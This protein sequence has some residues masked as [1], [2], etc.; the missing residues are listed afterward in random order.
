MWQALLPGLYMYAVHHVCSDTC[1]QVQA[2]LVQHFNGT[3]S[4]V[5]PSTLASV[6]C[7]LLWNAVR[8]KSFFYF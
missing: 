5:H 4:W 3:C 7:L 1:T 6:L 8:H 2:E